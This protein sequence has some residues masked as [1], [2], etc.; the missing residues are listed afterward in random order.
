MKTQNEELDQMCTEANKD[1]L[2]AMDVPAT[3]EQIARR[4]SLGMFGEGREAEAEKFWAEV[5]VGTRPDPRGFMPGILKNAAAVVA[6]F[7]SHSK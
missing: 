3:P 5:E 1:W 6:A 4:E 2:A 7:K